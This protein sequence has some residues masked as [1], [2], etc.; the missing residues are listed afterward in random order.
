MSNYELINKVL[1][2][3]KT[4]LPKE[5]YEDILYQSIVFLEVYTTKQDQENF[6]LVCQSDDLKPLVVLQSDTAL[7]LHSIVHTV[8]KLS[9]QKLI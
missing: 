1:T 4:N 7:F 6:C 3:F 5:E 2:D 9:T 8:S